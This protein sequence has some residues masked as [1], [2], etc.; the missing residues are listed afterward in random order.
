MPTVMVIGASRGIG[1]ELV[2][3]YA[4]DGWRVHA[5]TRTPAQ[6]G[7]LGTLRG[8][9]V[10]HALDVRSDAQLAALAAAVATEGIDVLIHNAGV[11]ERGMSR[12]AIMAIN[13]E[14]PIKTSVALLPA[15]L[16]STEKKLVLMTS[17]LGARYGSRR[18]LGLYGDSKAALNDHFRELAPAWGKAGIVAIVMHP[19]WVRTAMGGKGAPLAVTE[20]VTGMRRVIAQLTAVEHG[21]FWTWNGREHPW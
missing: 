4:Q 16:R 7:V 18:S 5:T 8:D 19:G 9:T 11:S 20:S 15:V 12:Q 3:Q 17:Q 13:A 6:P 2:R 1:L 21:R 10:L 14:A